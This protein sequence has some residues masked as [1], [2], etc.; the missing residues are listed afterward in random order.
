MTGISSNK[1]EKYAHLG[2][3]PDLLNPNKKM[4]NCD[5]KEKLLLT[6]ESQFPGFDK[7]NFFA[8]F[9]SLQ[10]TLENTANLAQQVTEEAR[11]DVIG[12][13][14]QTI[15]AKNLAPIEAKN[16]ELPLFIFEQLKDVQ[17]HTNNILSQ[18]A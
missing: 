1:S 12:L 17:S 4:E 16:K 3:Q 18:A 15:I 9:P 8:K 6:L 7:M 13:H 14:V 5:F 11:R 2:P 10:A